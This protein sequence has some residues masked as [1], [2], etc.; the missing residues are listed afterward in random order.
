MHI[1][2]RNFMQ[3]TTLA[4]PFLVL[5]NSIFFYCKILNP[6]LGPYTPCDLLRT[7]LIL[8]VK[9][10]IHYKFAFLSLNHKELFR[11][12]TMFWRKV[13]TWNI[14]P[15]LKVKWCIPKTITVCNWQTTLIVMYI[16]CVVTQLF[17]NGC[18][19]ECPREDLIK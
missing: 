7:S 17:I 3:N 15:P 14:P 12:N 13:G 11:E 2:Q 4:F 16:H 18:G 6:R 1:I 19:V 8:C 9:I 10:I 5:G